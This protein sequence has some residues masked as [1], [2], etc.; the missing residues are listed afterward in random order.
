M[1]NAIDHVEGLGS[2]VDIKAVE[3]S[4][5]G[6]ILYRHW[7]AKG[8]PKAVI[9][10]VHG[11]GEHSGR[12]QAFAEYFLERGV[13]VVAPDHLGH[14]ASPGAR[15]HLVEFEDYLRPLDELRD[16]IAHWYPNIPCF[17]IG[18][19]LGGLISAR[20]LLDHQ[21]RFAG[22]ALSAAALQAVESPSAF[23]M[24]LA[25]LFSR[26]L[27]KMGMLQL[28]ATQISRDPAVVHDYLGDPL[29]H[30]GKASAR[31]IVELF[32][33]MA[34]VERDREKIT[35]PVL[36]MHGSDDAMT[37]HEGSE[38]F[39]KAVSSEDK[40]LKIYQGLYHEIFNEP[41][42]LEVLGDLAAWLEARI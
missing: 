35:L 9:L 4:L 31:L 17:L 3:G 29:V 1:T 42:R 12:Y 19:S 34:L 36:V 18:H 11:L 39:Y 6:G 27:P 10:L 38:V 28:D 5:N 13:S 24:F 2:D 33:S 32:Q 40:T 15:T 22:A 25:R 14:G 30:N 20:F 8:L 23:E 7:R 26:F 16:L 21:S 37:A 41:E